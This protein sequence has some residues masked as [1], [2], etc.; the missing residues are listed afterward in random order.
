[1]RHL[2]PHQTGC[3]QGKAR[4]IQEDT[5][6]LASE[7]PAVSIMPTQQAA[8]AVAYGLPFRQTNPPEH[9]RRGR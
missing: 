8:A 2:S 3:G 9:R 7:I 5:K 1:M 6:R 4:A